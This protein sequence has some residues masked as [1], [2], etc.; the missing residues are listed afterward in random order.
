MGGGE[1]ERI[2]ESGKERRER[3][4]GE[5]SV[6]S[7][8]YCCRYCCVNRIPI[9]LRESKD[10]ICLE[11]AWSYVLSNQTSLSALLSVCV[12]AC[13]CACMCACVRACVCV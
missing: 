13:M 4:L 7:L 5:M 12:R 8:F 11:S 2:K 1:G 9:I 6:I 10:N 3:R